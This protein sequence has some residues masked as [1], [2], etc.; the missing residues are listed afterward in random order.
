MKTSHFRIA[1]GSKL[2]WA[3]IGL[4]VTMPVLFFIGGSFTNTLYRDVP[5]AGT[6]LTDIVARPALAL[7]MLAGMGAGIAAFITGLLAI[8]L[9]KENTLLVYLAIAIGA[10]LLVFLAGEFI[11]PH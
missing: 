1:P 8:I 6:I 3:S 10:L 5:A 9:K 4:I 11:S 2:G 7:T